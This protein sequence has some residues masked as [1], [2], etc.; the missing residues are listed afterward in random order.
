VL[1][2]AGDPTEEAISALHLGSL[3]ADEGR[4]G[5]ALPLLVR[6]RDLLRAAGDPM[7]EGHALSALSLAWWKSGDLVAARGAAEQAIERFRELGH[8]PSEGV[9]AYRLAAICRNLG[10]A[11]RSRHYADLA[12]ADGTTAGTRTTTALAELALAR[13]DLD[14]GDVDA[15][16]VRVSS[17]LDG[18]DVAADRWVLAEALEVTARLQLMRAQPAAAVLS[19]AADLRQLIGQPAAPADAAETAELMLEVQRRDPARPGAAPSATDAAGLRAWALDLCFGAIP[20]AG[21][22]TRSAP[23]S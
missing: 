8:L 2:D 16:A 21:S 7:Q 19:A 12:L 23:R 17:G 11:E 4:S 13:L 1:R 3:L 5:E 14:A 20:A 6:A 22:S 10:D 18:L 9:V 15:A